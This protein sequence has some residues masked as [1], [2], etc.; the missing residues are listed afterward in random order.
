MTI[1]RLET[2][3]FPY[4]DV[5]VTKFAQVLDLSRAGRAARTGTRVARV[6]RLIVHNVV[7]GRKKTNEGAH[8]QDKEDSELNVGKVL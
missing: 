4:A 3:A 8:F 7:E 6:A 2:Y 5:D 1:A